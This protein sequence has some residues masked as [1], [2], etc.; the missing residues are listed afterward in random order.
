[1]KKRH[2]IPVKILAIA[3]A[4]VWGV[5]LLCAAAYIA[6]I[7]V[8]G[9]QFHPV[10][11]EVEAVTPLLMP[12]RSAGA[13]GGNCDFNLSPSEYEELVQHP[14][15]YY[16]IRIYG[17]LSN[18]RKK[19]SSGYQFY[20]LLP[21][22]K[23]YW[24]N[25]A[26]TSMVEIQPSQSLNVVFTCY[27]KCNEDEIEDICDRILQKKTYPCIEY[28]PIFGWFAPSSFLSGF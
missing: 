18:P 23:T 4:T 14:D 20:G 28:E 12:Q 24:F 22:G 6:V 19:V 8:C 9:L 2:L 27:V 7:G 5:S 25:T 11:C 21:I 17:E 3:L 26:P 1:M 15:S 13:N 16:F 10:S